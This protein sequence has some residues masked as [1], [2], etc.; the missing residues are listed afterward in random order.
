M[1]TAQPASRETGPAPSQVS[2]ARCALTGAI[3][4]AALFVLSWLT[5]LVAGFGGLHMAMAV[6]PMGHAG[7]FFGFAIGIACA[8]AAGLFAGALTAFAYNA[9]EPL[10]R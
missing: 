4:F 9:L 8:A 6:V 1:S 10:A 7:S 2:V 3:V 5:S